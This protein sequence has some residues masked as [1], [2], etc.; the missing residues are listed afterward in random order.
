[1]TKCDANLK[2]SLP[3]RKMKGWRRRSAPIP[4]AAAAADPSEQRVGGCDSGESDGR[5]SET[6]T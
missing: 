5:D 3:A 4:A 2:Q 1:M 6:V